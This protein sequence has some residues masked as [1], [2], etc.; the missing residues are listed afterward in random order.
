MDSQ[1]VSDSHEDTNAQ[2]QNL[3]EKY[4]VL[5]TDP[6]PKEGIRMAMKCALEYK[7]THK[8]FP[9]INNLAEIAGCTPRFGKE[10]A[11]E[12]QDVGLNPKHH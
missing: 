6:Q 11:R 8:E 5:L 2:T 12:K 9:S 10:N 4:A 3:C 7:Q 1:N